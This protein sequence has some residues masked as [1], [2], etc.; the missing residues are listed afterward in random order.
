[1]S[2]TMPITPPATP[3][4]PSPRAGVPRWAWVLIAVLAAVAL[5]AVTLAVTGSD[6]G[7]PAAAPPPPSGQAADGCLGGAGDL[8][9]ALLTA[10]R[11]A[12]LT[13]EGAAAFTATL[14][15]WINAAPLPHAKVNTAEQIL[16]AA[17]TG[18]A[19]TAVSPFDPEDTTRRADFTAGRY[20][21]ES[22][23]GRAAVVSWSAGAAATKAGR[24][25]GPATIGGAAHLVAAD[26]VWRFQDQSLARPLED[27]QRL[28]I[29]YVRGC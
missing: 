16:S 14:Y 10:Q 12:P 13:P 11:E 9:Q 15:R 27:I 21:V 26:G 17:A 25:L 3:P 4:S 24:D 28:G 29:A 23:D 7:D 5:V 18:A 20:Y 6:E 22:F 8:D 2:A 1:M 19:R